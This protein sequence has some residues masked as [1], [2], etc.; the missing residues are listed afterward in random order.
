MAD[1]EKKILEGIKTFFLPEL[2]KLQEGQNALIVRVD[3][4][5]KQIT[6]MNDNIANNSMRIDKLYNRMDIKFDEINAKF[7]QVNEKIERRSEEIKTRFDIRFD[8]MNI[9][10]DHF[11]S[12][13]S[14]MRKELEELKRS[15]DANKYLVH[16][17]EELED[18][19]FVN[20]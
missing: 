9:R 11:Y 13:M 5:E 7:E 17:V 1:L 6:I 8:A 18:K 19:V 10:M 12:E 3:A 14:N 4:I 15:D 2:R 20:H 16:R